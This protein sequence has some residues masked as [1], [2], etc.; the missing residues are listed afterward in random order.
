MRNAK[1]AAVLTRIH[2]LIRLPSRSALGNA[3]GKA[4]FPHLLWSALGN[5]LASPAVAILGPG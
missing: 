5:G 2:M 4:S 1:E 3:S